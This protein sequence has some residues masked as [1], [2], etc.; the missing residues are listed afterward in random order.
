MSETMKLAFGL[1]QRPWG[2]FYLKNKI[3]GEQISLKTR[4]KDAAQRLLQARNESE[5]QP[6]FNV[7]LARP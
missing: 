4:D 1:V 5:F 6:Q 2:V 7:A 3:T